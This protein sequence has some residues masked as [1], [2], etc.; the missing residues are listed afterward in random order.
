MLAKNYKRLTQREQQNFKYIL[1]V[2][3][4]ETIMA[5]NFHH[6]NCELLHHTNHH[7]IEPLSTAAIYLKDQ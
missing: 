7:A 5:Q 3:Y 4:Y 6:T 1:W 2:S